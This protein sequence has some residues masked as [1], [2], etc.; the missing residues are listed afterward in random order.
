ME[1][2]IISDLQTKDPV[3][4]KYKSPTLVLF[5]S[6]KEILMIKEINKD[7]SLSKLSAVSI[8]IGEDEKKVHL[9]RQKESDCMPAYF[10]GSDLVDWFSYKISDIPWILLIANNEIIF[11]S[12][13]SSIE[14]PFLKSIL[15]R[16]PQFKQPKNHKNDGIDKIVGSKSLS[17]EEKINSLETISNQGQAEIKQLKK[18]L[19]AKDKIIRDILHKL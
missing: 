13:L 4:L 9:W 18:E 14:K 1:K 3:I 17:T 16:F 2:F 8:Y 7:I 11:S 15:H 5:F 6:L 12:S 10:G 19:E